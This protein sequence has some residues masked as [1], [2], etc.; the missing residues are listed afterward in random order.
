MPDGAAIVHLSITQQTCMRSYGF[1]G[2]FAH[3][4]PFMCMCMCAYVSILEN[5]SL[6]S[7]LGVMNASSEYIQTDAAINMGNSG[8]PL[9]KFT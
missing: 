9:G 2:P 7:E 4:R 8:G 3:Q 6:G 1:P 5:N